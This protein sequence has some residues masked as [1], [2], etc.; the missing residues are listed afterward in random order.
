MKKILLAMIVINLSLSTMSLASEEDV[1]ESF[2]TENLY[3]NQNY[4]KVKGL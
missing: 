3:L 2:N 4:I 1:I